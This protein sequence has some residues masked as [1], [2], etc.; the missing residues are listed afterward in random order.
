M[1]CHVRPVVH[2]DCETLPSVH[3]SF[4]LGVS[5]AS[6]D[7]IV[8]NVRSGGRSCGRAAEVRTKRWTYRS[9]S[10]PRDG[11]LRSGPACDAAVSP[12]NNAPAALA[13]IRGGN[14]GI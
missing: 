10:R 8:G 6:L 2:I 12:I 1:K 7:F 5:V 13:D 14:D 9:L 4:V 11:P 3:W